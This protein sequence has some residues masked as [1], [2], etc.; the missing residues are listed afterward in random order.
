MRKLSLYESLTECMK[1]KEIQTRMDAL[2]LIMVDIADEMIKNKTYPQSSDNFIREII[3]DNL[4]R[5]V[6]NR[7]NTIYGKSDS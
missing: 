7:Y 4:C 1:G 2:S 5:Q 3:F 6:T